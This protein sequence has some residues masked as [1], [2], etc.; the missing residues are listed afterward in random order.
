MLCTCLSIF[1]SVLFNEATTQ[2]SQIIEKMTNP[3]LIYYLSEQFIVSIAIFNTLQ[4]DLNWVN[5]GPILRGT[6]LIPNWEI[7]SKEEL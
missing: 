6:L 7:L 4:H 1:S 5:D 2:T 3:N